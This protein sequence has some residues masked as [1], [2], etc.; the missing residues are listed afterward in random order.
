MK[1]MD[2]LVDYGADAVRAIIAEGVEMAMTRFN[3][4]APGLH[5]EDE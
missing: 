5:T 2:E 4:R 3:R 1:E